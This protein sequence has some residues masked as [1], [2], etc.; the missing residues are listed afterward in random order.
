MS[1]SSRPV[2]VSRLR[3]LVA[4]GKYGKGSKSERQAV[5]IEAP[6]GRYVL[7]R[8]KGPAFG[9]ARLESYVGHVVECDGYLVGTTLL[10]DHIVVID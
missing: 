10:T 1:T 8:K 7:R 3:G 5:F 6:G 9:D 4:R 2:P